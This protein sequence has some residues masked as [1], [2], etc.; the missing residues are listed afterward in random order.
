MFIFKDLYTNRTLT[1]AF[2]DDLTPVHS[3]TK[4]RNAKE[5]YSPCR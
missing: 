5:S 1:E 4:D 2:K 3:G